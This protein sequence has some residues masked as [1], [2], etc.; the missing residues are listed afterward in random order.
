[1]YYCP[2]LRDR[3]CGAPKVSVWEG[4]VGGGE[5][6]QAGGL[7]TPEEAGTID[8]EP[9]AATGAP[10]RALTTLILVERSS[11]MGREGSGA[12]WE[13]MREVGGP[14]GDGPEARGQEWMEG[15][16]KACQRLLMCE[17]FLASTL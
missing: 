11:S 5:E 6:S 17:M 2:L 10:P 16:W 15:K 7:F 4:G 14:V 3:G 1:M 13:L 8:G 9:P 12:C